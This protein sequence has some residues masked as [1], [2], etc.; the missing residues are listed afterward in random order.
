MKKI[1]L[2][3]LLT[4]VLGFVA[5]NK[6]QGQGDCQNCPPQYPFCYILNIPN[7]ICPGE[8]QRTVKFCYNIENCPNRIDIYIMELEIG[9]ECY[10]EFWDWFPNWIGNNIASLCGYKPC[11]EPPPMEINYTVPI[12]GRVE[13][14][15]S[16]R[17]LVYRYGEGS[18]DK[19]CV[20][21]IL[22]CMRGNQSFW[23]IVNRTVIGNG[24]C[25]EI[26]YG[27]ETEFPFTTDPNN[28]FYSWQLDCTKID[29]VNCDD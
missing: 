7:D 6:A 12:C 13:W 15:G 18:C 27:D 17:R 11:D 23:Q 20:T 4:L 5:G 1:Y 8:E 3:L 2:V 24:N 19:R 22:W 25:P 21:K 14:Y 28:P 26:P 16:H 10:F 29:G 9:P